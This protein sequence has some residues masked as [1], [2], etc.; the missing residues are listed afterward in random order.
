MG[1]VGITAGTAAD[2]CNPYGR[3]GSPIAAVPGA[4]DSRLALRLNVPAYRLEVYDDGTRM[5]TYRVAVGTPD[6][7]TPAGEFLARRIVWNPWWVP[8]PFDWA[9]RDRVTSPGPD[10]PTGR[11]KIQ[12]DLYMYLH[13]TPDESALGQAA[14]HGCVRMANADAIELARR[15]QER[16]AP[17]VPAAAIDS[18]IARPGM[19]RA[20]P[21]EPPIPFTIEYRLAE[22]LG[23]RLLL[24]PD[25]YGRG[26]LT[27]ESVERLLANGLGPARR[28]EREILDALL[29][30][31][32]Y[33]HVS[34][35]LSDLLGPAPQ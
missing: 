27:R 30:R 26:G 31:A 16:T 32:A 15:L 19:T 24:H 17:D 5:G 22:I 13:G 20:Y 9:A 33:E 10:N 6:H 29:A 11:V 3:A 25:V 14:S 4:V 23:D 28:V 21:L 8:P 34:V 12:F 2:P 7:P 35:R 1:W 18:L